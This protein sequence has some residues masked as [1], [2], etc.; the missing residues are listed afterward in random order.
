[1]YEHLNK[2][3]ALL[4]LKQQIKSMVNFKTYQNNN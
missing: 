1:M 2:F 3:I 4:K